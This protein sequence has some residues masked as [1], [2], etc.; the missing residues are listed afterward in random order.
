MTASSAQEG[1]GAGLA[2]DG[3]PNKYWAPAK[4]GDGRGEYVETEFEDPVRLVY[5]LITPGVSS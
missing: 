5:V 3:T 1:H 4:A 2:K